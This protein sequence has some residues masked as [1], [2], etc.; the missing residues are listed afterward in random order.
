[1]RLDFY[2]ASECRVSPALVKVVAAPT[3]VGRGPGG[4][5]LLQPAV[6]N[7]SGGGEGDAK[8][9]AGVASAS[10]WAVSSWMEKERFGLVSELSADNFSRYDT[11]ILTL[12]SS[13]SSIRPKQ[14]T[15]TTHE[16][17]L[18]VVP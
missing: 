7:G 6:Y 8:R 2:Y 16:R 14:R 1:M 9:V 12:Q 18:I 4:R 3:G 17:R 15:R 11:T 5:Q 13:S 10:S